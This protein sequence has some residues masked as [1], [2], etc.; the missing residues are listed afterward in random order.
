MKKIQL[1]IFTLSFISAPLYA[2]EFFC[3]SGN[4]TCLIAAINEANRNGENNTINLEP[5]TYTLQVIDNNTE[6]PNGLPSITG[7]ISIL[8]LFPGGA[9]ITRNVGATAFR[10]F[11]VA[12]SG[13][14]SLDTIEVSQGVSGGGGA[15]IFN[16]GELSMNWSMVTR[17]NGFGLGSG[18][19]VLINFGRTSVQ[20]T[21]MSLNFANPLFVRTGVDRNEGE[22]EISR[23][24]IQDNDGVGISNIGNL[25]LSDATIERNLYGIDGIGGGGTVRVERAAIVRNQAYGVRG[26]TGT[27]SNS[28]IADNSSFGVDGTDIQLLN[29]TVTGNYLGVVGA[30]IKN[31]IVTGNTQ[32]GDCLLSQSLG[33]NMF[34]EVSASCET[35]PSDMIGVDP[36]LGAFQDLFEPGRSH[37][38]LL[39]DSPAIDS[40]NPDACPEFDQLGNPRVGICDRGAIE[41]QGEA[42]PL[43]EEEP[44]T[45]A[46]AE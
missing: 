43:V 19:T 29:S 4:V 37:Y 25:I 9:T 44:T 32:Q 38:P 15:A 2:A 46:Q 11:H 27:I 18:G 3:P 20:N 30:F 28:T 16:R 21:E 35:Q 24:R 42:T 17:N 12:A 39:A 41:F 13:A 26:V 45:L 23:V 10:I 33:Y 34:T 14:L 36:R 1:A 31:S 5:G 6:G 40:A 7:R 22:M 8:G